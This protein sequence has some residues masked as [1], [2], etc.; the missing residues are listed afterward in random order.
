MVITSAGFEA[1]A[2][3]LMDPETTPEARRLLAAEVRDS[4]EVVHGVESP[5][6]LRHLIPAFHAVRTTL[7]TPQHTDSVVLEILEPVAA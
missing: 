5:A 2:A 4:A 7:T 1:H 6:F 3:K